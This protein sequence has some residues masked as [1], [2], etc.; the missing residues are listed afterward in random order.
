MPVTIKAKKEYTI[1]PTTSWQTLILDKS[2]K[3]ISLNRNFYLN[4]ARKK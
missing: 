3:R 4:L 2:G 1:S